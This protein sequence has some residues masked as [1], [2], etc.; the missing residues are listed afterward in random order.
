MRK[1]I[2]IFDI[3]G[4]IFRS[5]LAIELL[6]ELSASD[7]FPKSAWK[8]IDKER[9][10]WLDREGGYEMFENMTVVQWKQHVAGKRQ[11]DVVK[12][13]RQMLK[14]MK[15]RTYRYTRHLIQELK[16]SHFIIGISG[17]PIE[18]VTEYN[19]FLG[20][21]KIYGTEH[22]TDEKGRYTGNV[23]HEPPLYKKE[24]IARYIRNH[25][26]SLKGSLGVGDT[27]SDIG[28]LE[29]VDKP[30]AFNPNFELGEYAK[31]KNWTI[32]VERKDLIYEFK[33]KSVKYLHVR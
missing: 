4:T 2:A 5:S 1:P 28:F 24:I 3:D 18:A 9:Q 29:L 13:C 22:G 23:I 11:K 32:V 14:R 19:K 21:N 30:I 26:L 31:K 33:P 7:V 12:A 27:Q 25:N 17:S 16:K 6:R 15:K 10:K 20:F 8:Q